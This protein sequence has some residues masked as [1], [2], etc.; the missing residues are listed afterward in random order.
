MNVAVKL[1]HH[2]KID[3]TLI[4]SNEDRAALMKISELSNSQGSELDA[5]F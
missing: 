1:S 4:E 3:V 5:D 2:E